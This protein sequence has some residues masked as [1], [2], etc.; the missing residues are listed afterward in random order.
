MIIRPALKRDLIECGKLGDIPEFELPGG[1]HIDKKF[2]E[3]YLDKNFFLVAQENSKI[4]GYIVGEPLKGGGVIV[5]YMTIKKGNQGK[6]FGKKLLSEFE[7]RCRQNGRNYI[8]LYGPLS[9][10]KTLGFYEKMKY[11]RGRTFFEF[12]KEF[13]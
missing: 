11:V 7:K 2:M 12:V 5:W 9:N 10:K 13:K 3:N 6:G 8:E 4:I 1:G